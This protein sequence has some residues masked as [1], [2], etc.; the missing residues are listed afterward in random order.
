MPEVEAR[1]RQVPERKLSDE[2]KTISSLI[3]DIHFAMLTTVTAEGSLRS[4]PMAT[5]SQRDFDGDL[6][7]FTQASSA[8]VAEIAGN[9]QVNLSYSSADENRFVSISGQASL[10]RDRA[11]IEEHWNAD[12]RRWFP[13]GLDDPDLVLLKVNVWDVE[14]WDEHSNTMLQLA[15]IARALM[16]GQNYDPSEHAKIHI[17]AAHPAQGER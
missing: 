12:L 1:D 14:Y 2:L 11:A 4:R 3:K 15:G 9:P 17:H 7:F 10:V 13:D 6:W 8:K 5:Q 16:T